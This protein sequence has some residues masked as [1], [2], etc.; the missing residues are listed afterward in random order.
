MQGNLPSKI[1]FK[2]HFYILTA[3]VRVGRFLK[4]G[5]FVCS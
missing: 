2:K 4:N 3:K 1:F 5:I